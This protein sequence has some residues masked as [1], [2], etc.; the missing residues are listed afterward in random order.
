MLAGYPTSALDCGGGFSPFGGIDG[1]GGMSPFNALAANKLPT[2]GGGSASPLSPGYSPQKV[3]GLSDQKKL[4][5][6]HLAFVSAQWAAH[7]WCSMFQADILRRVRAPILVVIGLC[8]LRYTEAVEKIRQRRMY[9]FAFAFWYRW[10]SVYYDDFCFGP[11]AG[12]FYARWP[13]LRF[14]GFNLA[15]PAPPSAAQHQHVVKYRRFCC[16]LF[17]VVQSDLRATASS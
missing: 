9:G 15:K 4:N 17:S 13:L 16:C 10:L 7:C 14:C 2:C 8:R 11:A 3:V 1:G 6:N 5:I 12:S